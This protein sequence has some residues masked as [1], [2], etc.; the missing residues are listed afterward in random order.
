MLLKTQYQLFDQAVNNNKQLLDLNRKQFELLELKSLNFASHIGAAL[1]LIM[2]SASTE[3]ENLRS[4]L[5]GQIQ[6]NI[7]LLSYMEDL[8]RNM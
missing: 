6:A 5:E 7:R 1:N 4:H 3:F 2:S 8:Q